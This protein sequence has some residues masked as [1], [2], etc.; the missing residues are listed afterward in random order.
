MEETL[1]L[2]IQAD[3]AELT[4]GDLKQGI[5]DIN[6]ELLNVEKGS[7]KYNE[8]VHTLGRARGEFMDIKEE[9]NA[10]NPER[11][12]A[13]F[14]QV[15]TSL[16]SGFQLA[17]GAMALMGVESE[18]TQKMLL[19]VQAAT[20]M[21]QGVQSV[22]D[23]GKA[24]KLLS[25]IIM[26]N[27]IMTIAAVIGAAA[28]AIGVFT[29]EEEKA[30]EVQKDLNAELEKTASLMKGFGREALSTDEVIGRLESNIK[31]SAV[32]TDELE[33]AMSDLKAQQKGI[34]EENQAYIGTQEEKF[35]NEQE[36]NEWAK[37]AAQQQRDD[38]QKNI[39]L[40]NAEIAARGAQ[41]DMDKKQRELIESQKKLK[42]EQFSF[43]QEALKSEAEGEKQILADVTESIKADTEER[44]AA[45]E[46]LAKREAAAEKNLTVDTLADIDKRTAADIEAKAKRDAIMAASFSG[47]SNILNALSNLQNVKL[48]ADLQ[49]AG[50][51]EKKKHQLMVAAAKK[52]KKMQI[53]LATIDMARAIAAANTLVPPASYIAM[54]AAA[55]TGGIQIAAI[56]KVPLPEE[57]G[58][59][60]GGGGS[61]S[62][63]TPSAIPA[64]EQKLHGQGTGTNTDQNQNFTGFE[65][66]NQP[67]IKTYVV[68]SEMTDT[69]AKIRRI[70]DAATF[71]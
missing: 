58:G 56:A 70:K 2:R 24:F 3:D 44:A 32:T 1:I 17:T 45:K 65:G 39:D 13:A 51:N 40:I 43:E 71:P 7:A 8:L 6:K 4:V 14:A 36:F 15:G 12:A 21:A 25:V 16:A 11:R 54:A 48:Q 41:A 5:K 23:L 20:A 30:V 55:I 34:T 64:P 68:E 35:S 42:A 9:A 67:A 31:K 57:G 26:A 62:T 19:K 61:P 28:V 18:D 29:S 49:A 47:A 37:V 46:S 33:K 69:Q 52:Q 66:Q 53:A 60:E 22:G 38:I 59:G 50:S 63:P 27:P 10:F